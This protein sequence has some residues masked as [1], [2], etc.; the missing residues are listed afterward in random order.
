MQVKQIKSDF[1]AGILSFSINGRTDLEI[2]S[3]GVADAQNCKIGIMGGVINKTIKKTKIGTWT[4]EG[5]PNNQVNRM[6]VKTGEGT[7]VMKEGTVEKEGKVYKA[8]QTENL[9]VSTIQSNGT[10]TK[11]SDY[12][13]R[14]AQR[15]DL[16]EARKFRYDP[17]DMSF[18]IEKKSESSPPQIVVVY[19]GIGKFVQEKNIDGV[20][21]YEYDIVTNPA[22]DT[23]KITTEGNRVVENH[24]LQANKIKV[25]DQYFDTF[26]SLVLY[27]NRL[28]CTN[29]TNKNNVVLM[30]CSDDLFNF[31]NNQNMSGEAIKYTFPEAQVIYS[32]F[33]FKSLL[34][35][36]SQGIWALDRNQALTPLNVPF[37]EV[38]A[39]PPAPEIAPAKV[40]SKLFYVNKSKTKIFMLEYI[41]SN[42]LT[43]F[44]TLDTTTVIDGK[45]KDI[46]FICPVQIAGN[47][48]YSM[49]Y[50]QT[51][52]ESYLFTIVVE[53]EVQHWTRLTQS[54]DFEHYQF[55]GD[56]VYYF[57]KDGNVYKLEEEVTDT[58]KITLLKPYGSVNTPKGEELISF[59]KSYQILSMKIMVRGK[60]SLE[61]GVERKSGLVPFAAREYQKDNLAVKAKRPSNFWEEDIGLPV[62]V[63]KNRFSKGFTDVS[64]VEISDSLTTFFED[65]IYVKITTKNECTILGIE[66]D[67]RV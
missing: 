47:D 13:P 28:V 16:P 7:F 49:L 4:K 8:V 2:Y 37:D 26:N 20:I 58:S 45:L 64:L 10:K 12:V 1:T 39:V 54:L 23:V 42:E 36:T 44:R 67:V 35:F 30:S 22:F 21:F 38:L 55:F 61:I 31:E 15:K 65:D 5:T 17:R 59:N 33:E 29:A 53:E 63:E 34:L 57:G 3:K 27:R 48:G 41:T 43:G 56:D 19:E 24:E 50:V 6:V 66:F 9:S 46:E 18:Y 62:K 51:K 14:E 25:L 60:Y 52:T 40:G 32:A 11:E